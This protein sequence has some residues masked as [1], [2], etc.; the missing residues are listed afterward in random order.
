[1]CGFTDSV[2]EQRADGSEADNSS[3]HGEARPLLEKNGSKNIYT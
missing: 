1:M 3:S 2:E